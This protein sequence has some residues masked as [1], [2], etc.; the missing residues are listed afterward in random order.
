M[1]NDK[2]QNIAQ[3]K[4]GVDMA[5]FLLGKIQYGKFK[6]IH[7]PLVKREIAFRT[8]QAIDDTLGIRA[9]TLILRN[10]KKEKKGKDLKFC[11]PHSKPGKDWDVEYV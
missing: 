4:V 7:I 3:L 9:L 10:N 6:T 2:R 11:K 1:N 8:Q 5:P